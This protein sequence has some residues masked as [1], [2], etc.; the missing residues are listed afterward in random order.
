MICIG[1]VFAYCFIA[2][3][4]AV[5]SFCLT[6]QPVVVAKGDGSI[7]AAPGPKRRILANELTYRRLCK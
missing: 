2:A 1:V 7:A 3:P 5:D 6:Y 4:S